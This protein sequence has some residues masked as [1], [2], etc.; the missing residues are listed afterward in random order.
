MKTKILIT[1]ALPIIFASSCCILVGDSYYELTEAEKQL[2]PYELG[3]IISF[4]N[5]EGKT[6]DAEITYFKIYQQ[7]TDNSGFCTSYEYIDYK[8]VR[9]TSESTDFEIALSVN[10]QD[11]RISIGMISPLRFV[12]YSMYNKNGKFDDQY[13][14]DSLEINNRVYYDV[15]EQNKADIQVLYNKTYGILQINKDGDN[16]IRINH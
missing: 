4:I 3:Q 5:S 13:T 15:L 9:L 10:G 6:F 2:I 8:M 1:L 11:H 7:E 16:F 14:H 12:L